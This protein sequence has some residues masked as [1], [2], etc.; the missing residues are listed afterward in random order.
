MPDIDIRHIA[1][2]ARLH[3]EENEIPKLKKQMGEIVGMV[4]NLP[5]FTD[6]NLPLNKEDAMRLRR[7][8]VRDSMKREEILKNAPA[9]EAGCIVVPKIV[10]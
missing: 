9:T 3:L 5:E 1:K 7:D 4:E 10:E 2:L 8:E 6:T